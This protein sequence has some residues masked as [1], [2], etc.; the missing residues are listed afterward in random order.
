MKIILLRVLYAILFIPTLIFG[1]FLFL[2]HAL[3]YWI[4]TGEEMP[5][6]PDYLIYIL[7]DVF[8]DEDLYD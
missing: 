3:L 5:G 4:V 2:P 1:M 8:F 7:H 6:G